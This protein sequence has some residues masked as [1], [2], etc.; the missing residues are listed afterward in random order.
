M[1]DF[2]RFFFA[3]RGEKEPTKVRKVPLTSD[4]IPWEYDL[5]RA[6]DLAGNTRKFVLADFSREN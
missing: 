4:T 2:C 3:L 6:L 1:I 5:L